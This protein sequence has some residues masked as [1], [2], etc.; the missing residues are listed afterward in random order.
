MKLDNDMSIS[1][2]KGYSTKRLV[3]G[4]VTED[5]ESHYHKLHTLTICKEY[6]DRED[7]V[8]VLEEVVEDTK[9]LLQMLEKELA[10]VHRDREWFKGTEFEF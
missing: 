1:I 6:P 2:K 8:A 10:K 5:E 9:A 4:K 7:D 3:D